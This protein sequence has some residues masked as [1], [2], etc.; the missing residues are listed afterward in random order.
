MKYEML[1][2][3][4]R[5]KTLERVNQYFDKTFYF[6][7]QFQHKDFEARFPVEYHNTPIGDLQGEA[8][9][10]NEYLFEESQRWIKPT[11]S[12]L[13]EKIAL[14]VLSKR[15]SPYKSSFKKFLR[16]TGL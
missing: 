15:K 5:I 16:Q 1:S 6:K 7:V 12:L 13:C 14:E 4:E 10:L 2:K 8:K 9:A 11:Y 3:E